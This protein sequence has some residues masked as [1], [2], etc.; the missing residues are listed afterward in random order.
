MKITVGENTFNAQFASTV[1]WNEKLEL[2]ISYE[3]SRPFAEIVRTWDGN[4]KIITENQFGDVQEFTGFGVIRRI[5][6]DSE[7]E[8]FVSLMEGANRNA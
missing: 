3:D 2:A 4:K 7:T 1:P 5:V 6:R 8:V